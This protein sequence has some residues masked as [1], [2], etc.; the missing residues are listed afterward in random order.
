VPFL[1]VCSNERLTDHDDKMAASMDGKTDD[2]PKQKPYVPPFLPT[3]D[4]IRE[5]LNKVN[6]YINYAKLPE[7]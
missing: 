4:Y 5:H 7:M 6:F 1:Y 2:K 3:A